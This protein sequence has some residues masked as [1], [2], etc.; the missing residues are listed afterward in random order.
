[1]IRCSSYRCGPG[2]VNGNN[3]RRHAG[4]ATALVGMLTMAACNS[5][6]DRGMTGGHAAIESD[7]AGHE[8]SESV[9][10]P[11]VRDQLLE[12]M[13]IDQEIRE[14]G[15]QLHGN[16][17]NDEQGDATPIII[18]SGDTGGHD[19]ENLPVENNHVHG[20]EMLD[21]DQINTAKLKKI[22]EAHGWPTIPMVGPEGALAAWLIVQH[23]DL[24][25]AFQR[26]CLEM[27]KQLP[28]GAV[29]LSHIAYLTDRV[30]VNDGRPQVYGTQ[31]TL[32]N[33][34]MVPQPIEDPEGLDARRAAMKLIT[35]AEYTEHMEGHQEGPMV[36]HE[37]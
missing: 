28:E 24:E 34:K 35:M 32:A 21:V 13:A 5:T 7:H 1:M 12:M 4:V 30:A 25:P 36:G 19:T 31:F 16:A 20:Q 26:R 22:I 11:E 3:V 29:A 8:S 27:L 37:N 18:V 9:A 2:T 23:A 15:H 6:A 33:G 17:Q 14:Q 10:L